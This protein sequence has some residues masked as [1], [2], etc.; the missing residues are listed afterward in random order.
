MCLC[1]ARCRCC[2]CKGVGAEEQS[3]LVDVLA[4]GLRLPAVPLECGHPEKRGEG[5]GEPGG[6]GA[7]RRTLERSSS[8]RNTCGCRGRSRRRPA[9]DVEEEAGP[10]AHDLLRLLLPREEDILLLQLLVRRGLHGINGVCSAGFFGGVRRGRSREGE[11]EKMAAVAEG[12][13]GERN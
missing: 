3:V 13:K 2:A 4:I 5:R 10:G 8:S 7:H 1:A 11:A 9:I 12:G 6:G